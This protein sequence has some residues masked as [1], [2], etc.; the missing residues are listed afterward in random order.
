MK[1]L[2]YLESTWEEFR[3]EIKEE[4][5][6]LLIPI[7]CL[8]E[9]GPHLPINCDCVIGE[10]ICESVATDCNIILGPPIRFGES[11]KTQGLPGT[12]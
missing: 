7:G 10:K 11:R 2:N 8:E 5:S 1:Y 3:D 4:N 6:L 9:H 12:M